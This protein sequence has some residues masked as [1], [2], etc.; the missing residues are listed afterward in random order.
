MTKKTTEKTP[1]Q[2]DAAP[3]TRRARQRIDTRNQVY[4]AAIAEFKKSGIANTQIEAI[5][6][7]AG[8]SVGTFYRYFSGRDDV[9]RELQRRN[10]ALIIER[11]DRLRKPA[12]LAGYLKQLLTVL[13]LDAPPAELVLERDALTTLVKSPPE[14]DSIEL[15]PVY[16]GV[17]A[18]LRDG[19]AAGAIRADIPAETLGKLFFHQVFGVLAGT[20]R[21]HRHPAELEALLAVYLRGVANPP[22][23]APGKSKPGKRPAPAR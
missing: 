6:S 23:P 21:E 16:G 9:L 3:L 1:A 7:R 22:A 17:I 20:L 12:D 14:P 18:R 13:L 4:E 2:A 5:V 8:V 10:A 19:Q 11:V 15:H